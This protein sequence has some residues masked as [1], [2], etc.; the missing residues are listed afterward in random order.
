MSTKSIIFCFIFFLTREHPWP[1]G[2]TD[3]YDVLTTMESLSKPMKIY[4]ET[5]LR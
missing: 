5:P 3:K 4:V 2:G 1:P